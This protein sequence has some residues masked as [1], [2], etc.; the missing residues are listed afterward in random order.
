MLVLSG[1]V[2]VGVE[3]AIGCSQIEHI[4][5]FFPFSDPAKLA[6]GTLTIVATGE[7]GK[8]QLGHGVIFRGRRLRSSHRTLVVGAADAELVMILRQRLQSRGLYLSSAPCQPPGGRLMRKRIYHPL[9]LTVKSISEVVYAFPA[10]T[11]SCTLMPL[12]R[13]TFHST[14]MGCASAL[15]YLSLS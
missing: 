9:T 11:T 3:V 5:F 15:M 6:T 10:A 12:A 4:S 13:K 2:A 14:Q 7:D 8:T 1:R